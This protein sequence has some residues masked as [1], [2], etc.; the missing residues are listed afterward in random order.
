[1]VRVGQRYLIAAVA[2]AATA[3]WTGVG[4]V[5]GFECLI[6]FA[7]VAL[8]VAAIQRRDQAKAAR[9]GRGADARA[10][11]RRTVRG[12]RRAG[13]PPRGSSAWPARPPFDDEQSE[14]WRK[15]ARSDW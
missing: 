12:G 14:G 6:V 13:T 1:M 3:L 7:L 2:F 10:R 9:A 5:Q 8:S 15:A 4:L 11:R